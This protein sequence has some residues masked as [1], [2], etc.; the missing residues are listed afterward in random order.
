MDA[1][2][3]NARL[4]CDAGFPD[5]AEVDLGLADDGGCRRD[6]R[7][8][9]P[10][11]V[12]ISEKRILRRVGALAREVDAWSRGGRVVVVGVLNGSIL[13]LADL[14][15]RLRSPVVLDCIA[16][17]SYG[18]ARTSSGRVLFNRRLRLN[19]RGAKVLLVDDILDT[20]RTLAALSRF[21]RKLGARRVE[22]CVLLRKNVPRAADVSARFV[23]FDIPDRFVY[24]YGLDL[25][26]RFRNLRDI[27]CAP[28]SKIK[29]E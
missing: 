9:P 8:P 22:T 12:L 4:R 14:V 18:T 21:L 3:L 16:A 29:P 24:G 1:L 15:R 11:R 6:G 23:G 5:V 26:E 7:M 13:F 19:V 20:G 25:R 27:A 28:P 17:S 2:F 10:P